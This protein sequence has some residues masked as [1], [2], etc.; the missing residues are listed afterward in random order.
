MDGKHLTEAQQERKRVYS[1][2]RLENKHQLTITV[3][4]ETT[5]RERLEP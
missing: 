5:K 1:L 3:S 2:T 4:V